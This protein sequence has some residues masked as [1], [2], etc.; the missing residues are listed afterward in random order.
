[1]IPL[2]HLSTK[3]WEPTPLHSRVKS[4]TPGPAFT[5]PKDCRVTHPALR[6][7]PPEEKTHGSSGS[8]SCEPARSVWSHG[9]VTLSHSLTCVFVFF[10]PPEKLEDVLKATKRHCMGSAPRAKLSEMIN[11]ILLVYN[12][13]CPSP[14]AHGFVF[15]AQKSFH[16]LLC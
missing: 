7:A 3:P 12:S 13:G 11:R 15:L 16:C 1:M 10:F 8:D 6:P 2:S 5:A 14:T 9:D 4:K